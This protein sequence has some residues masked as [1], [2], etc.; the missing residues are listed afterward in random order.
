MNYRGGR[1]R[2]ANMKFIKWKGA[3]I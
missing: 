2:S 3:F 1:V